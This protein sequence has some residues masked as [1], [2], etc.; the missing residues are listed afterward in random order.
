MARKARWQESSEDAADEFGF[1]ER[2]NL[3][4]QTQTTQKKTEEVTTSQTS[5]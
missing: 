4:S 1:G 3:A 2:G 5:N